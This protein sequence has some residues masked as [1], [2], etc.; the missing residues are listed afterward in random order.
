MQY[1]VSH[2]QRGIVC[3]FDKKKRLLQKINTSVSAMISEE[4]CLYMLEGDCSGWVWLF[5]TRNASVTN[6]YSV[7]STKAISC[8]QNVRLL[9][10]QTCSP[11]VHFLAI[12]M[13]DVAGSERVTA[14]GSVLNTLFA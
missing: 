7:R 14:N 5:D 8:S 2:G 9:P 3:I 1:I 13:H 6:I 11:Y 4:Q 12:A 10:L